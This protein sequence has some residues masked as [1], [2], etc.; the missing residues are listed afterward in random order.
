MDKSLTTRQSRGG[1]MNFTNEQSAVIDFEKGCVVVIAGAGSG[2]TRCLVERTARLVDVGY[3]P[4]GILLFTFTRKAADEIKERIAHR[5]EQ[6]P[7]DLSVCTSTI[8]SLALRIFRENKDLL[9]YDTN[10]TI[11]DP[12]RRG[13][14][15]K[16]AVKAFLEIKRSFDGEADCYKFVLSED[17]PELEKEL[18]EQAKIAIDRDEYKPYP[19]KIGLTAIAYYNKVLAL[20]RRDSN[21]DQDS[22]VAIATILAEY[23]KTKD[24]CSAIEFDDM[25]PAAIQILNIGCSYNYLFEHIMIDEYQDVNQ[26]NVDFVKALRGDQT[27][28]VMAVGDDD[29]SIY[30]FRGGN[31]K[32]I[33]DFPWGI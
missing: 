33:L 7:A 2:K 29:Q 8:H 14:L 20:E 25:I 11:W 21:M 26:V 3:T 4:S 18:F 27:I 10:P 1:E 28:S 24:F 32:H 9:G 22:A 23:K 13:K 30:G 16:S 17:I 19:E 5:L 12:M 31:V 15:L 6:D